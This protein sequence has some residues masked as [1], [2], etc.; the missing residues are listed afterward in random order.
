MSCTQPGA[1]VPRALPPA[2]FPP[3][4]TPARD[5]WQEQ[6]CECCERFG[7]LP[8]SLHKWQLT[9][10]Q[11]QHLHSLFFFC[12]C[13]PGAGLSAEGS[14]RGGGS[15][16][17]AGCAW[18]SL[19]FLPLFL[20]PAMPPEQ[21]MRELL[22]GLGALPLPFSLR[23]PFPSGCCQTTRDSSPTSPRGF[24]LTETRGAAVGTSGCR[25]SQRDPKHGEGGGH[26]LPR[27]RGVSAPFVGPALT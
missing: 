6:S 8:A 10:M 18:V 5:C 14:A 12:F 20:H 24:E 15:G 7:I 25:Q 1:I 26:C 4:S 27:L 16:G 23:E 19:G 21:S 2:A 3:A 13:I 17:F 9:L 11:S 22:R